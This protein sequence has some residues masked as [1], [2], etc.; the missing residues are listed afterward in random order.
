MKSCPPIVRAALVV[1]VFAGN[2]AWARAQEFDGRREV[3]RTL[4]V[5]IQLPRD[6]TKCPA[7]IEVAVDGADY[8]QSTTATPGGTFLFTDVP[9]GDYVVEVRSPGYESTRTEIRDWSGISDIS[10]PLGRPVAD[11]KALA[12]PGSP[13]VSLRTLK[14]P[15]KAMKLAARAQAESDKQNLEEA[16][17]WLQKAV[18]V[19]PDFVE[20]WNN[21][22][23]T[24][25]R[26]GKQKEAESAFLKALETH[27]QAVP[28]LRNLGYLYLRTERPRE[29]LSVLLRAREAQGEKDIYIETYLGHA[30]Y[31]T[32][33]YR[34]AEAVLK[35][36]I[37]IKS[38]FAPALYPL[39][40]AQVQ[41]HEY[42][43]ARRTFTRFLEASDKGSEADVARSLLAR[44]GNMLEEDERRSAE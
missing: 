13:T 17:E 38:D 7:S 28:A 30:L 23:V 1:L 39:A 41:L 9:S 18:A 2:S 20:A 10:V 42:Q 4:I 15:T 12:P 14:V 33:Q 43:D 5:S 6:M 35:G 31:G 24:Y 26:M 19:F 44:L 8:H 27:S 40:L 34:E 21:M 25:M 3:R 16:V 22:G 29:A 36:A 37:R 32:R 11:G